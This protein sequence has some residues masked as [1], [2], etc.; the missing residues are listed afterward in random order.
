M[1]LFVSILSPFRSNILLLRGKSRS[2]ENQ[3]SDS[4]GTDA[5]VSTEALSATD[6]EESTTFVSRSTS[7]ETVVNKDEVSPEEQVAEIA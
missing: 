2:K 7:V 4:R 1:S 5:A 3:P 6:D